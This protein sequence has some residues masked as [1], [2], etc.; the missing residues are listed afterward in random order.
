MGMPLSLPSSLT[1][2]ARTQPVR[3][4]RQ[5]ARQGL[6]RFV[7]DAR[8]VLLATRDEQVPQVAGSL[9]FTTVLAM[10]PLLVIV[11]AVLTA[12]PVFNQF[13]ESLRQLLLENLVPPSFSDTI[14]RYLNSFAARARGLTLFGLFGLA[15]TAMMM[16]L[17]IDR[18][19]NAIW[20]VQRP[21]P[22]GQRLVIYGAV[23][24]IGPLLFAASLAL[25]SYAVSSFDLARRPPL[26]LRVT[27]D[28]LPFAVSV[29]ALA[30]MYRY[31]PNRLV[32]WRD[33]FFGSL[34][35]ALCYELAKL[36]FALYITRFSGYSRLYGALAVFPVFLLWIYL[37]WLITL[38][39][40]VVAATGPTRRHADWR[41]RRI[42][43]AALIEALMVL[44]ALRPG[45]PGA[46]GLTLEDL[47]A[48][49]RLPVA[50]VE[51]LL[52]AMERGH[53]VFRV[54]RPARHGLARWTPGD[55]WI[56]ARAPEALRL[57]DVFRALLFDGPALAV[58][59]D[60]AGGDL[61]RVLEHCEPVAAGQ[62]LADVFARLG[63]AGVSSESRPGSA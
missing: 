20:R 51:R 3:T 47:A 40:G 43:G 60:A 56:M 19:V 33:A 41:R 10:V 13:R 22:I 49:V 32:A 1:A 35:A 2:L 37:S 9:T 17:T 26:F 38:V 7:R 11:F 42:P 14:F 29:V 58:L 27:L 24:T 23:L 50:D 59:P 53:L 34:F 5:H 28:W 55:V 36:G 21:R 16:V 12:F 31:M 30:C 8:T 39:G 45:A 48:T 15:L 54:R 63:A 61:A 57:G 52:R 62:T 6:A 25:T 44:R 4:A 18:A 46:L